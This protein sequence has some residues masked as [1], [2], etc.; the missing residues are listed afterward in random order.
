MQEMSKDE[1]EYHRLTANIASAET[2]HDEKVAWEE[3][4]KFRKEHP[5]LADRIQSRRWLD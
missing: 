3:F 5:V 1:H 2:D 4:N